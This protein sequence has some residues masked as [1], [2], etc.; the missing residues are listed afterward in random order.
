MDRTQDIDDST[1][2]INRDNQGNGFDLVPLTHDTAPNSQRVQRWGD[3]R[4]PVTPADVVSEIVDAASGIDAKISSDMPASTSCEGYS[5]SLY[6][7]VWV[8]VDEADK[9]VRSIR[10]ECGG[11]RRDVR[12]AS[13][14]QTGDAIDITREALTRHID[15]DVLT[16]EAALDALVAG[17]GLNSHALNDSFDGMSDETIECI[18]TVVKHAHPDA[19]RYTHFWLDIMIDATDPCFV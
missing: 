12:I 13:R 16:V 3:G 8:P 14:D 19:R 2:P 7:H 9:F 1:E 11:D 4:Y 18:E 5:A 6:L 17:Y 10:D 15:T